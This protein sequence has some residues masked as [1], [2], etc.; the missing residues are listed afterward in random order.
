M[1]VLTANCWC[2]SGR[3]APFSAHY[4]RCLECET[5]CLAAMPDPDSL[6]VKDDDRDF[7]G[8]NY[9]DR[10]A[11][12]HGFPLLED[13]ARGELT[14][15]CVYWL[16]SLL[17]RILPPGRTL[18]LGCSHGGFVALMRAAGF[19]ATGLDLSPDAMEKARRRF[20]IPVLVGP[21]EAQ[22]IDSGSLD[23]V[24]LMDVL[25]H[26]P[27]PLETVRHCQGLLKT[28]G[29]LLIQT[30]QYREGKL[31]HTMQQEGDPFLEQLKEDQ[32]LYL[33][34]K[35]SVQLLLRRAGAGFVEFE[36][37]IFGH[38]DMVLAA[39]RARLAEHTP[40]ENAA[41]LTAR[42]SRRLALAL[43]DLEEQRRNLRARVG[44]LAVPSKGRPKPTVLDRLQRSLIYRAM[45]TLGLWEWLEAGIKDK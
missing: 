20:D 13:R 5:L 3:L 29:I 30:P 2:G 38:Y 6:L 31:H 25:E 26:L 43:L 28:G 37:A 40:E 15:R 22:P 36:P 14:E 19:D 45:R 34:S 18:E 10:M 16:R 11:Q 27:Q 9:F 21:V 23:A 35:S 1:S 41:S 17:R 8:T 39:G 44:E 24:I 4:L 42:P 12:A 32:H 33:F 7:Y